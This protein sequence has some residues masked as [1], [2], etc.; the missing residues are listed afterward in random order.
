MPGLGRA[1]GAREMTQYFRELFV[2]PEDLS[3]VNSIATRRSPLPVTAAPGYPMPSSSFG[4]RYGVG[5]V[6]G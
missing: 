5:G 3:L 6:G 2:L 1:H 4:W